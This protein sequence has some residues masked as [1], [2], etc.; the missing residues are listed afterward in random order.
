MEY[1]FLEIPGRPIAKSNTYRARVVGG[2]KK[3]AI[4]YTTRELEEYEMMVGRIAND[5]IPETIN[6][7]ASAYVRVYQHGK[8][9]IDIDNTFKGILDGLDKT[10]TIKRGK[11]EIR[12][13]ETGIANDRYFQLVVGERIHVANA[14]E[15]R[16]EVI[17]SEYKGLIEL[18]DI[19][20]HHYE[21]DKGYYEELLYPEI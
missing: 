12:V 15:Q 5:V 17:I 8:T 10:K 11:N 4:I 19:I 7:F 18:I 14:D 21:I 2:N 20:K 1:Y 9:W 16:V 3:R 6:T 13:C